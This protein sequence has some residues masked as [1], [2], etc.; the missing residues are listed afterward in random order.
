MNIYQQS[1]LKMYLTVRIYLLSN[2]AITAKLPNFAEF[3]TALDAAILQI[4]T[5]SEQRQYNTTGVADNKQQL[6]D[7]IVSLTVDASAKMQAF[8]KYTHNT[9]LLSETKFKKS[10]L[11]HIS[12]LEL[13]DI[14]SGLHSRI[15]LHLVNLNLYGLTAATQTDFRTV[16]D[17][18]KESIPQPRQSQLKSKENTLLETQGF[19]AADEAIG[20]IDSV[21]EIVK[22]TEPLFYAGYKNARKIVE[23]GTGSL[24]VQGI[25]TEAATGK[26]IPNATLTF[27]QSGT[28]EV[29]M[30]K[31]TAAK[32]GFMI[33]SLAEGIYDVT[34][35]K[36]GFQTHT[37]TV[38]VRWDQLCNVEVGLEKV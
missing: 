30:E 17:S 32:G 18:Y 14:A 22:L 3:L 7:E 21:V 33:K 24:Q 36:V 26:P 10:D 5:N 16:I 2:P 23:Q 29:A 37:N 25:V 11:I 35:T 20:N 19:A 4:E 12:S 38:T 15:N 28:T 1:K 31:E 9:V 34:V 6:R 27:R 13:V 8:A